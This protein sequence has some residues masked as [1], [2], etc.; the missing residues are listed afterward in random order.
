MVRL[1]R[2]GRRTT[3]AWT[4]PFEELVPARDL[5]YAFVALY[6]GVE[7]LARL[8]GDRGKARALFDSGARLARLIDGM[9]GADLS[10]DVSPQPEP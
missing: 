1:R 3:A 5:A 10:V 4:S 7:T 8:D 6:F 2:G 9:F